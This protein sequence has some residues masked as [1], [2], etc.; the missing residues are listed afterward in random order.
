MLSPKGTVSKN[1][2]V[3]LCEINRDTNFRLKIF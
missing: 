2:K 1:N 3:A